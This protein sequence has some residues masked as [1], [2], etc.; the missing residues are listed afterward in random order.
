[1]NPATSTVAKKAGGEPAVIAAPPLA[2]RVSLEFR[3][4][5]L[6]SLSFS[7]G[8]DLANPCLLGGWF[9]GR[10]SPVLASLSASAVRASLIAF[11][12][13]TTVPTAAG[14]KHTADSSDDV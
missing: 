5:L 7:G 11:L 14:A 9:S 13:T 1:M 12:V 2:S 10:A 6:D 8:L 4:G 3:R